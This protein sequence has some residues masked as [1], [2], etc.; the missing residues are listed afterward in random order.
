VHDPFS[1]KIGKPWY[2]VAV[3]SGRFGQHFTN[4]LAQLRCHAFVGVDPQNPVAGALPQREVLGRRVTLPRPHENLI[5]EFPRQLGR[6]VIT[7]GI[8][9]HDFLHPIQRRQTFLQIL[10]LVFCDDKRRQAGRVRHFRRF[11]SS[12]ARWRRRVKSKSIHQRGAFSQFR[13][14]YSPE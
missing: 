1:E 10:R 2:L 6:A 5:S 14:R 3:M 13:L 8:D 9:H 4:L 11:P 7:F 12:E